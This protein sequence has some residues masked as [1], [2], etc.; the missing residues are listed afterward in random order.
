MVA[1]VIPGLNDSE[2]PALVAASVA[3]GA[4]CVGHTM[5][6]LPGAV[7]G[8]FE[9]WLERHFPDRKAR[10]LGRIRSVHGG[11]L[12]DPRFGHRMRGHGP[13]ADL[14]H[15]TFRMAC[16]R[17]GLSGG[18]PQLSAASFRRPGGTQRLLFE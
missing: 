7:A 11:R 4:T 15:Q 9:A 5:L 16:R 6:H 14:I 2:I 13:Y 17:A 1:P 18:L 10:V 12:N 8:L 3:A